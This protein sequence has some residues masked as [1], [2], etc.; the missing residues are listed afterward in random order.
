MGAW[1]TLS[2][3]IYNRIANYV[4]KTIES[5]KNYD[6]CVNTECE[7]L[8]IASYV[9]T[10]NQEIVLNGNINF[11][12]LLE[13]LKKF[14]DTKIKLKE[15]ILLKIFYRLI[16][17]EKE[18]ALFKA[19]VELSYEFRAD[20]DKPLN[21]HRAKEEFMLNKKVDPNTAAELLDKF[22]KEY[23]LCRREIPIKLLKI[24]GEKSN[25]SIFRKDT[26][27]E[28]YK[29]ENL[30]DALLSDEYLERVLNHINEGR[31]DVASDNLSTRF[32]SIFIDYCEL[33][34]VR[35]FDNLVDKVNPL[36]DASMINHK[37]SNHNISLALSAEYFFDELI[38]EIINDRPLILTGDCQHLGEA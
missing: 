34:N 3:V 11:F 23:E 16:V 17:F 38:D 15:N 18:L 2:A 20:I 6:N 35:F 12:G 10:Y 22:Y 19:M 9:D 4:P 21:L 25:T 26:S 28:R 27:T 14:D 5:S 33:A 8:A 24:L 36:Y 13:S 29:L 31:E 32:M 30:K 7:N 1:I 37:M